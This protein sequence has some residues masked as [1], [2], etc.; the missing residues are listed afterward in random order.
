M[1]NNG[2]KLKAAFINMPFGR[3]DFPSLALTQCCAVLQRLLPMIQTEILYLNHDYAKFFGLYD[4]QQMLGDTVYLKTKNIA[5]NETPYDKKKLG[6]ENHSDFAS[7]GEWIFQQLAFGEDFRMDDSYLTKFFNHSDDLKNRLLKKRQFLGEY[8]DHLIDKYRLD[9]YDVLCFTSLFQQQSAIIAIGKKLK[10]RNP[11]VKIIAGGCNFNYGTGPIWLYEG[12]PLD[13][14]LQGPGLVSLVNLMECLLKNVSP[15]NAAIEGLIYREIPD[16]C[17]MDGKRMDLA[18][19]PELDYTSYLDSFYHF[20]QGTKIEP[21]LFFQTS[22]GCWWGEKSPCTFCDC[23]VGSFQYHSL[24]PEQAVEMINRML[25]R[26]AD[27]C[28][29]FW[30]V[31]AVIDSSY[32]NQ[33]LPYIEKNEQVHIFYEIRA[34][35]SKKN[36]PQLVNANINLVQAGIEALCNRQLKLMNKGTTAVTNLALLKNSTEAGI[37]VLWNLLA[38]IPGEDIQSFVLYQTLLPRLIHLYPPTGCWPISHDHDCDLVKNREKYHLDLK[39]DISVLSYLYPFD[40]A[41][42]KMMAYF[43][44]NTLMQEQFTLSAVYLIQKIN[45]IINQWQ[46]KWNQEEDEQ[47][48]RLYFDEAANLIDSRYEQKIEHR[49]SEKEIEILH[50]LDTGEKIRKFEQIF[51]NCEKEVKHLD[52]LGLIWKHEHEII[53]LVMLKKP[54][55]PKTYKDTVGWIWK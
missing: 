43:Y 18:E 47:L 30:A 50:S 10:K 45:E 1:E 21:I 44:K 23:T 28:R 41:D 52:E 8:T 54:V 5:L 20:F 31:D 48:P 14:I 33:V 53:S 39:E 16:E 15:E 38:G 29:Y 7:A 22:E 27:R 11:R 35:I 25:S 9:Q 46:E 13:Y 2:I 55:L 4:Y 37:S 51:P 49:L 36:I 34:N 6:F 24:P 26:Y 19:I 3:I 32:F 42:L 12:S 40:S 17:I